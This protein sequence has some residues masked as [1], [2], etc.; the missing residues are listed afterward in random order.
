MFKNLLLWLILGTVLTS[1]FSQFQIGDQKNEI[2]YSQ[3]IQSV[4]QGDVSRV[5]ISGNNIDGVGA[6][7][8]VFS[9]YSPGDL[10]LMG[11][12]LNNGVSVEAK[13]P[14]KDGFFKQLLISL[15]PI[16]L[17]IGVIL[18]T[19]KGAGG[20]MGGRNPMS[21]GKSK[22]RLITKD[23]SNTTFDD[24]AGVDEAKEDVAE[25]VDFLSDPGKFT[26][27]G[28]KIPKGVLMVGPPGTGKTLLAKAIAGEADVP[29][30]FISGSDFVEMFVG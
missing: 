13:P 25:L 29:F 23:E 28:G 30:F 2:T 7:G 14:E 20:S 22:A 17:L 3:F 26:K 1:L 27:V 10:G 15:A 24:V 8:E 9:T 21:F 12:L 4:K 6:G 19:M 11:D 5:T 18:Y 16:L